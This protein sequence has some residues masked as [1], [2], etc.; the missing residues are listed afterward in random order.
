MRLL[1]TIRTANRAPKR[2][3]LGQTVRQMLARSQ[4]FPPSD[5]HIFPTDPDIAWLHREL[6]DVPWLDR[7]WDRLP[8]VRVHVPDHH[9]APNANGVRQVRVD[10][11]PT[12]WLV[13]LEDDVEVCADFYGSVERWLT[14]YADPDI[15]VYRLHALPETPLKRVG[16]YAALAPLREMKGSQAVVLRMWDALLFASWA[17]AHPRNWRPKDAPFQQHPERGFD[18]LIG[19]WALQQWP[20]QPNG[21]V[22]LPM[23]VNHIG[24][25]SALHSHGLRNDARFAGAQ[26]RYQGAAS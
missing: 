12:D 2:N 8:V 17:T 21:L 11:N 19:Y 3:Y 14:D 13:M 24:R 1:F 26:W 4:D 6:G 10:G 15:H 20:D 25:E 18:K 5:L 23:L 7:D 9:C 22:A 16:K